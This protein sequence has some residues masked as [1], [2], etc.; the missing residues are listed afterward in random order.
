MKEYWC[1]A[2]A[3]C[4]LVFLL[5]S[6]DTAATNEKLR[7]RLL[8]NTEGFDENYSFSEMELMKNEDSFFHFDR[9]LY[10]SLSMPPS[11]CDES[12]G[13]KSKS[14]KS[15]KSKCGESKSGKS[16]SGKSKCGE[17]KSGKS[18]SGKSKSGKSKSSK[19]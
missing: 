10:H 1:L 4:G 17:S 5:Q 11:K 13:G 12:K 18:K 14:G 16:K 2:L 8:H 19:A 9:E 6:V 15:G 3:L 7:K